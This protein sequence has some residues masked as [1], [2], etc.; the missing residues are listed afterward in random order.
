MTRWRRF[1]AANDHP[2]HDTIATFRRRF[3]AE[4]EAQIAGLTTGFTGADLANLVNEAAIVP[5]RRKADAVTLDD[6]TAAIERIVAGLEKKS[7]V[8]GP[9][10]RRRVSHHEMGHAAEVSALRG[11]ARDT[12]RKRR[13]FDPYARRDASGDAPAMGIVLKA[14]NRRT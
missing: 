4:I 6:F 1:I 5:T 8:L 14:T 3:L 10:E 2:D 11:D 7:R 12:R 9:A 13:F